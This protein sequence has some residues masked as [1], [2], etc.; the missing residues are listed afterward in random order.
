M[1]NL[2]AIF[3]TSTKKNETRI[4]LHPDLFN[5]IPQNIKKNLLFEKG[6]GKRF[7]ISDEY[8][9]E[10]FAGVASREDLFSLSDIWVLPKPEKEDFKFFSKNKI[11]FGWLHCVQGREITQA[12]IENDMTLIAWEAM[13]GGNDKTHIFNRNNELA[14]YAAVQHMLMLQG[15]NGY[16]GKKLKAAVLGFGA[17][18]RG[19]INSLKSLGINEITTFSNRPQFLIK[20]PIES[21]DY[22]RIFTENRDVYLESNS[23]EKKEPIDVLKNYDIII[24]CVLQNPTSPI[25]FIKNNDIDKITK[26]TTIIDISCDKNMGFEFASPTYFDEPFINISENI[27]Y[28]SIDNTPS[29]YW[30]SAS[31]EITKSLIPFLELF[32]SN[33]WEKDPIIKNAIEIQ[34]GIIKNKKIIE[35]QKR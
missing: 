23:Q 35:F 9:S 17:T 27:K 15:I 30:D 4:P 3:G 26:K 25:I 33:L 20:S 31:Y 7:N 28:Y 21:I 11:L 10:F 16:F 19:A 5:L 12:A 1:C 6:Y 24:N 29:I 2:I 34:N 18:A 13:Y 8:F 32:I 14:G 22:K